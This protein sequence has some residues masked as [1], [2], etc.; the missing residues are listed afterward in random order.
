[1]N[2]RNKGK[3]EIHTGNIIA[4]EIDK[5]NS[6]NNVLNDLHNAAD[7]IEFLGNDGHPIKFSI[8]SN[9]NSKLKI[10][11]DNFS[12]VNFVDSFK[13]APEERQI[14]FKTWSKF[15]SQLVKLGYQIK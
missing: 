12:G 6:I 15:W 2:K 7:Q 11:M 3:I 5:S 14:L 9:N 8:M 1:M 10:K 4:I 13:D